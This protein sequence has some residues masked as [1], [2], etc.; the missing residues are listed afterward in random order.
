[1]VGCCEYS[2]EPL[3]SGTMELVRGVETL[4]CSGTHQGVSTDIHCSHVYRGYSTTNSSEFLL[5]F[6]TA[7]M[8]IKLFHVMYIKSISTYIYVCTYSP[9]SCIPLL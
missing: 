6:I 9:S 3:G 4:K 5:L 7:G 1:V 8:Q 2:D